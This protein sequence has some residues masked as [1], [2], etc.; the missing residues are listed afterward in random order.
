MG[1]RGMM[2][3]SCKQYLWTVVKVAKKILY[4]EQHLYHLKTQLLSF[5]CYL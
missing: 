1:E 2:T 3:G 5:L 4:L